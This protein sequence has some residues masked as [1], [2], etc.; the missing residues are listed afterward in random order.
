MRRLSGRTS[1]ARRL[2]LLVVSG[3]LSFGVLAQI[4]LPTLGWLGCLLAGVAAWHGRWAKSVLVLLI[5]GGM[6]TAVGLGIGGLSSAHPE[7]LPGAGRLQRLEVEVDRVEEGQWPS[8]TRWVRLSVDVLRGGRSGLQ[9]GERLEVLFSQARLGWLSGDRFQMVARPSLPHGLCNAGVDRRARNAKRRGIVARLR[10][11]DD[12]AVERLPPGRS[13]RVRVRAAIERALERGVP[14]SARPVLRALLLGGR[15]GLDHE[16]LA[17]W[18][19]A[20]VA[21]LLVVSGLHLAAVFWGAQLVLSF[22]AHLV[23]PISRWPWARILARVLTLVVV[24]FYVLVVGFSV[25]VM[26]AALVAFLMQFHEFFGGVARPLPFLLAVAAGFLLL[27]PDYARAAGFQLTFVATGALL[28]GSAA[29]RPTRATRDQQ[30][31]GRILWRLRTAAILSLLVVLATAPILAYHFGE[32]SLAGV[33]TNLLAGPVLG[34]GVLAL[35]L[36]GAMVAPFHLGLASVLLRAAA[37]PID[38]IEPLILLVGASRWGVVSA[39]WFSPAGWLAAAACLLWG[40]LHR[41][42][43]LLGSRL[44]LALLLLG[45]F[46]FAYLQRPENAFLRIQFLDVGQGD[47]I[48]LAGPGESSATVVDLPGSLHATGLASRVVAPVLQDSRLSGVHRII[49]SHADWDHAGGLAALWAKYPQAEF[50]VSGQS[51]LDR[52]GP[53]WGQAPRAEWTRLGAGDVLSAGRSSVEV[54]QPGDQPMG[55]RNNNSLVLQIRYGATTVLLTGDIEAP[56]EARLG[57]RPSLGGATLLKVPHHGSRTS[58][59]PSLLARLL[60]TVAVA[61][62]ASQNRFGFPHEEVVERYRKLKTAWLSTDTHGA[63]GMV[64]DGQL[65]RLRP[66][67]KPEAWMG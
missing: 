34:S 33:F 12:R 27:D 45:V 3:A 55:G 25:S 29:V 44:G 59:Q 14:G 19:A 42:G 48:L 41:R 62:L 8:G 36:P 4:F 28:L 30:P 57:E 15:Q 17:D 22:L 2:G 54:L 60:P 26:R 49:A 10:I 47:S 46:T 67:R 31:G 7:L 11:K 18:A 38:A 1:R 51:A 52:R 64:S 40:W 39:D 53:G 13:L 23:L 6:G 50:M 56:A 66:C 16:R 65:S 32:F 9:R 35:A 20:G 61:Q 37:V 58:S 5:L 24:L 43:S 21:H 63:I